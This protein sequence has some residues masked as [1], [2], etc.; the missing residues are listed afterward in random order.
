MKFYVPAFALLIIA[1]GAFGSD[2]HKIDVDAESDDGILLQRI[3]QEP[4]AKR[5]VALLEKYASLF[6]RT[7][8]IAWV[9]EQ[10]LPIYVDAKE[11][12]KVLV[13]AESLL[14]VDPTDVDAA[15][16]ALHTAE[17]LHDTPLV[18]KYAALAWDVASRAAKSK[19][20]A[21]PEDVPDWTKQLE[22]AKQVMNYAEYVLSNQAMAESD[23][24]R[25]AD[26]LRQLELRNA[27]S[28]FLIAARTKPVRVDFAS[29]SPEKA[30]RG[31]VDDPENIDYLMNVADYNMRRERDLQK[32]LNYSIRILDV[33][34][35]KPRPEGTTPEEWERK[36]AKYTGSANWMVGVVYGKQGRYGLSERY[37]RA[38]LSNIRDNTQALA[39]AY[40]YLGYDNYAM[41]AELHDKSKAVEAVRYSRLC[42]AIEGPFQPL[43]QK[44]LDV[45]RNEYNVE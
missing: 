3:Q 29:M 16:A 27:Q 4:L 24:Q 14:S 33:I 19:R 32:V 28:K 42:V 35:R 5:K 21:D 18:Q 1:G 23:P 15:D 44:N 41:A 6:P 25:K 37:L 45:L 8:S 12:D 39:A 13:T 2:R 34:Q 31:L 30:E 40:F 43:A 10:L 9:Y 17:G 11:F 22:F 7:T 36:K 38:S 26:L 20:P